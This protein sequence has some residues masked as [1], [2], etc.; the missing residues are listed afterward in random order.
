MDDIFLEAS[1]EEQLLARL[2]ETMEDARCCNIMFCISKFSTGTKAVTG[3]F[4]IVCDPT[5]QERPTIGPDPARV[6]KLM[7][8]RRPTSI[9]EMRSFLGLLTQLS[10][11]LLNYAQATP[12]L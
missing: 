6:K 1:L 7:E 8:L 2:C 11:F 12:A 5:G 4:K 3:G 9:S 10:K